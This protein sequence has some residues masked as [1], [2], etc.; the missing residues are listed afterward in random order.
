MYNLL[1]DLLNLNI[2]D[3]NKVKIINNINNNTINNIINNNIFISE[4][5]N[6]N[7]KKFLIY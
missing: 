2:Q 4:K 6:I 5:L 3:I 7:I 1:K